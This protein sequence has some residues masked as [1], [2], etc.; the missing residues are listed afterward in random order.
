M[1][2][3]GAI[4]SIISGLMGEEAHLHKKSLRL[5]PGPAPY[6]R[7]DIASDASSCLK[8]AMLSEWQIKS[9]AH[10]CA[11]THAPFSEGEVIYT[12]L[13][14][15]ESGFR[16]EDICEAAWPSYQETIQ[17]FS[18]WK[19]TYEN[20]PPP[21]PEPLPKESVETH[22]RKLIQEDQPAETNARYI[23]ALMLERKKTLKQVDVRQTGNERVL[24]YEHA[25]TGE[26]F[27]ILDPQLR[28]DQLDSVQ[29]EVYAFLSP[30]EQTLQPE[31]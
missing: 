15:D 9:R 28:L 10:A 4:R 17:P 25:K 1:V 29:A 24:I 27:L 20:P 18:F 12:L 26:V 21:P 11:R 13:F 3:P 7:P 31:Q 8:E 30:P 22:L 6:P 16:R 5:R 2:A 23:L 19:S 14:R